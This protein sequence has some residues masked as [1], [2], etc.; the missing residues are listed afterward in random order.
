MCITSNPPKN[1]DLKL[2]G[3]ESIGE[4]VKLLLGFA[5]VFNIHLLNC[6]GG[7]GVDGIDVLNDFD[8]YVSGTE[9]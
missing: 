5:G 3:F 9:S 8:G 1:K 7:G 4:K 2:A 6:F